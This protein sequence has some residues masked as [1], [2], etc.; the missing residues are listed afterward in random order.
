MIKIVDKKK[1]F[2]EHIAELRRFLLLNIFSYLIIFAICFYF[3]NEIYSIFSSSLATSLLDK[4]L[5]ADFI[6]TSVTEVFGTYIKLAFFVSLIFFLPIFLLFLFIYFY[7]I[8]SSKERNISI[9]L[10]FLIPIL[11]FMG[12]AF[13]FFIGFGVV[14]DFF[15]ELSTKNS[16][17][18]ILPKVSEYISLVLSITIA[19]G[20]AFEI[21][22]LLVLLHI[23][24]II[25]E[26]DIL[27][28]AKYAIVIA[29]VLGAMLTPP[30][31]LSQIIVALIMIILYYLS[32][33]I[34]RFINK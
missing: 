3:A 28:F 9:L 22:V 30:D 13:T 25:N 16:Q 31:P 29:F 10:L 2:K 24:N 19:F 23:L 17:I 4:G 14:W 6:V 27:R 7:P 15:I 26:K 32:Y 34:V 18:V 12:V 33:F 21:P 8:L 11:F 5:D 20:L 1:T